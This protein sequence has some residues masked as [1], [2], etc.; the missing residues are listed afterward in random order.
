MVIIFYCVLVSGSGTFWLDHIFAGGCERALVR[1][2]VRALLPCAFLSTVLS[3]YA[4][5][6]QA[7]EGTLVL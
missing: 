1:A 6:W 5:A 3:A 4:R 7:Q 2:L